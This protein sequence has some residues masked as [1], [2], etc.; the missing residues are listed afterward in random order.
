MYD[1]HIRPG[2]AYFVKKIKKIS[3]MMIYQFLN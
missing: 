3:K 2:F 1:R